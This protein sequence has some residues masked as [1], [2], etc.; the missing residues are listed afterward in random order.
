[1]E[2]RSVN[3]DV[4]PVFWKDQAFV[5]HTA[6]VLQFDRNSHLTRTESKRDITPEVIR[7]T[8]VACADLQ[9]LGIVASA[10]RSQGIVDPF[11]S[12]QLQLFQRLQS[13]GSTKVSFVPR[14]QQVFVN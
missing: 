11:C 1:M 12:T 4:G 2:I 13:W 6:E 5:S 10:S 7:K 14:N 8:P 9:M 3:R